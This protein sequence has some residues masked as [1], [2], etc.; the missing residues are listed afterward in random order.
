MNDDKEYSKC[1]KCIRC[2]WCKAYDKTD[3]SLNDCNDFIDYETHMN[4]YVLLNI[5]NLKSKKMN[6]LIT[7]NFESD[8]DTA[9]RFLKLV[10]NLTNKNIDG[11]LIKVAI[12]ELET[13]IF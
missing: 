6:N 3:L 5:K 4:K 10:E 7:I 1:V 11:Q 13:N 12:V 8:N 9:N 2:E